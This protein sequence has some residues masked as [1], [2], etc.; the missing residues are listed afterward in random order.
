MERM[1]DLISAIARFSDHVDIVRPYLLK[2]GA[3]HKMVPLKT[4]DLCNFRDVFIDTAATTCGARWEE[5]HAQAFQEA[6]DDT[7][8]PIV[9]EGLRD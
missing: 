1:M 7:I 4:Q 6:F 9:Y 2:V 8:I 5:R 3:A